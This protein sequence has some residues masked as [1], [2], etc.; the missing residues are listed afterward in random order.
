MWRLLK[1]I[2]SDTSGSYRLCSGNI[3]RGRMRA[4]PSSM[5]SAGV[6]SVV[7]LHEVTHDLQPA[8]W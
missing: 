5:A 7:G 1:P 8:E 6:S 3:W 4:M 2:S